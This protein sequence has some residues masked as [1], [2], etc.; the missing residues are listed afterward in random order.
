MS[1]KIIMPML[2]SRDSGKDFNRFSSI[3]LGFLNPT[4][5]RNREGRQRWYTLGTDFDQEMD[6]R[7]V[8]VHEASGLGQF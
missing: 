1:Y 4:S 6:N 3:G 5:Q 7:Q 8:I 2:P